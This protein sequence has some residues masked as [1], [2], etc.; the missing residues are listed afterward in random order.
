MITYEFDQKSLSKLSKFFMQFDDR[1]KRALKNAINK[2]ARKTRT[3]L[4]S[5]T[6][7]VYTHAKARQVQ[8]AE[9]LTNA[10]AA[11][12]EAKIIVKGR[13]MLVQSGFKATT[14]KRGAKV[15]V[16]GDLRELI[17]PSGIRGFGH[18][19]MVLQ[20]KT[21]AR[22]PLRAPV[23]PSVPNMMR[24]EGEVYQKVEPE[25]QDTLQKNVEAEVRRILSS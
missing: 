9:K 21:E 14:P 8:N 5:T 25:I 23:G 13:P 18:N 11:N 4:K 20:R 24:P 7:S 15:A 1:A 19:G 22:R 6:T 3:D 12:L 2:T 10:S 16:K 17:G